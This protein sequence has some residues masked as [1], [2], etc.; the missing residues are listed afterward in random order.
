MQGGMQKPAACLLILMT[1]HVLA[2]EGVRSTTK[3]CGAFALTNN[4]VR[5]TVVWENPGRLFNLPAFSLS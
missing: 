2:L 1:G 4:A 5:V 3:K